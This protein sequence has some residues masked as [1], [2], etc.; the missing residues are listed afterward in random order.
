[1]NIKIELRIVTDDDEAIINEEILTLEKTHDRL[2]AMGLSLAEAKDLLARLQERVVAAQATTF[3]AERRPC[4]CC[5]RLQQSKGRYPMTFRTP[6]GDVSLPSPRFH[7]CSCQPANTKTFSPL[8][9]LFTSHIAPEMLYLETK[10]ASLVSYGMTVDL[11]REALPI[12]ASLN[13]ETVRQHLHRTATRAESELGK[14]QF[15]FVDGCQRTWR[16][17]PHP[18]GRYF[19]L[20]QSLDQK[21]K[22]RLHE[23]LSEQGLQMNQEIT[24]LTYITNNATTIP[25]GTVMV[26]GCRLGSWS[27]PSTP[28]LESA[29]P[30]VS[31]CDGPKR[32]LIS[33]CKPEHEP[34]TARYERNSRAGTQV[35]QA[36]SPRYQSRS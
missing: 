6:F 20:V 31:R 16:D 33:S 25:N 22:R 9:E 4:P 13:A 19:G 34:S 17:L 12:G 35:W 32:A 18:E 27:R 2:E 7:R 28:W 23:V 26:S 5:G 10:W 24:F 29:S 14:E 11:L 30:S 1:M 15:A 36:I 8:T 3:I 21:P